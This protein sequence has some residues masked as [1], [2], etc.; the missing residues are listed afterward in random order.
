VRNLFLN[1]EGYFAF[2]GVEQDVSGEARQTALALGKAIGATRKGCI[3]VTFRDE[4]MMDL[5][6]EQAI[7]PMIIS[8]ITE[9]FSF[10]VEKGHPAE[11][12]LVELYIC[13]EPAYM[14]EKMAEYGL[15]GQM[16]FHSHTSQYGQYSRAEALDKLFIRETL[17]NAYAQIENGVFAREW[18]AEQEKGLPE[19]RRLQEQAFTSDLAKLE[20][21]LLKE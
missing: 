1:A 9:A 15:Y 8:I 4:T 21:K 2:V 6:A 3:E 17:E 7:W 13:K 20:E 5:L 10:E 14:F 19:F 12:S 11:A 18:K 16:P